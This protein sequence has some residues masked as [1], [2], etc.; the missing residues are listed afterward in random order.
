M[1]LEDLTVAEQELLWKVQSVTGLMEEKHEQL[2]QLGVYSDYAKIYQAYADLISSDEQD[3]EALK[4]AI[5]LSWYQFAEPSCFSGLWNLPEQMTNFIYETLEHKIENN[6][7]DV[8][9]KWMLPFYNDVLELPFS[10]YPQL[11]HLQSFLRTA[12]PDLWR[13]EIKRNDLSLRGQM[14][15]YWLTIENETSTSYL[16]AS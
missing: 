5:F 2:E 13:R 10:L 16:N 1:N 8:E 14:G 12:N 11:N 3:L 7:L 6:L 4:R 9:L 15:E